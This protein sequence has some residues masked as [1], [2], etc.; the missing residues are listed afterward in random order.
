MGKEAILQTIIFGS[1]L[2]VALGGVIISF[3][4]L[5]QRKK[6]LHRQE[7]MQLQENFDKEML[8][9]KNEIQ[10]QTLQHIASEIHDN[11]NPTLSVINLNLASVIP[12]VEEPV[13]TTVADTKLLVKQ[14][15]AELRGL[16]ASLYPPPVLL[17]LMVYNP[18]FLKCSTYFSSACINPT[19]KI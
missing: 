13:K 19:F 5:H 3:V 10:E 1:V 8:H 18:V 9:S 4:L 7:M 12:A 6:Y 2:F 14:L 11:L 17:K 15:M 16:S